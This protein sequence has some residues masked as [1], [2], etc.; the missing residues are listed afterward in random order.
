MTHKGVQSLAKALQANSP[1]HSLYIGGNPIGDTGAQYIAEVLSQ[2][3]VIKALQIGPYQ[4]ADNGMICLA[5][6]LRRNDTLTTL[7]LD[8]NLLT[9]NGV[10]VIMDALCNN[11]RLRA[12]G[13]NALSTPITPAG[14]SISI[15]FTNAGIYYY[16]CKNHPGMAA[17]INVTSTW[18]WVQR[19][20]NTLTQG[21]ES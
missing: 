3:T 13:A 15:T 4:I 12:N 9:D 2:T 1:L 17:M 18:V 14:T 21:M 11:R 5:E 16:G 20:H 19:C 6:M 7:Y 10:K 8:N